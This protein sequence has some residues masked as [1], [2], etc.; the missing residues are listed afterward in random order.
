MVHTPL[1]ILAAAAVAAALSALPFAA[2]AQ[3]IPLTVSGGY[4]GTSDGHD[5]FTGVV[6]INGLG[7]GVPGLHPQASFAYPFGD[8]GGRYAATAEETLRL[9]AGIF[10]G[11]GVGVGRLNVPFS[12]PFGT[13]ALYDVLAGFRVAPHVDVVGRYYHGFNRNVGQGAFGGLAFHL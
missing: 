9:P 1:R 8:G 13:G 2:S 3:S 10:V 11:A 4:M 6:T 5:A 12:G 7:V